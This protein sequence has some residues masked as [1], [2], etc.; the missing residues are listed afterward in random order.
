MS[1]IEKILAPM[2]VENLF[3][4]FHPLLDQI[5]SPGGLLLAGAATASLHLDHVNNFSDLKAFLQNYHTQLLAPIELPLIC[6]AHLHASQNQFSELIAL[7][8][9]LIGE[10]H[11]KFFA[12]ASQRVG[13]IQLRRLRPLRDQ[14]GL[15]RYISAV[16]SGNAH[17]WHTLVYGMTLASFFIPL[18]QGLLNYSEQVIAGFVSAASRRFLLTET[19]GQQLVE[20]IC[21]TI[22]ASIEQALITKSFCSMA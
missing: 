20:E 11:L 8:Q 16:D 5:G 15:R 1:A 14:R 3:Q 9:N 18:R 19:D 21:S 10:T 17:A 2:P 4:D 22:P 12:Q 13:R 6:Q 7:D